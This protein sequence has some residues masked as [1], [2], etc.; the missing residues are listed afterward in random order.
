MNLS[1]IFIVYLLIL[2]P[3]IS[4]AASLEEFWEYLF[5]TAGPITRSTVQKRLYN[6][7]GKE[8]MIARTY[9]GCE[10]EASV[11][12]IK[13]MWHDITGQR[14]EKRTC[15]VTV[16]PGNKVSVS[17]I[18]KTVFVESMN[19]KLVTTSG[20]SEYISI[21]EINEHNVLIVAY[22]ENGVISYV[23][24]TTYDWNDN[25]VY[26]A[27]QDEWDTWEDSIKYCVITPM[28]QPMCEYSNK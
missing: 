8:M 10:A 27:L 7:S 3:I 5:P 21:G 16:H 2:F 22:D 4:S 6:P 1:K 9:T 14:I 17:F 15:S 28:Y 18:D 26:S 23:M 11:H 25:V 13:Q 20:R 24:Y 19:K 12:I